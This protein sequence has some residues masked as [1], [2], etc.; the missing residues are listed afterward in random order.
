MKK[1]IVSFISL[2]FLLCLSIVSVQAQ[3]LPE[4]PPFEIFIREPYEEEYNGYDAKGTMWGLIFVKSD[5]GGGLYKVTLQVHFKFRVYDEEENVVAIVRSRMTYT[6]TGYIAEPIDPYTG[7]FVAS[8]VFI[9]KAGFEIPFE[10]HGHYI[11]MYKDGNI[12]KELGT[13]PPF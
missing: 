7:R 2:I 11:A 10:P 8:W 13:E 12:V 1:K 6:G 4:P 3:E 9:T 5:E